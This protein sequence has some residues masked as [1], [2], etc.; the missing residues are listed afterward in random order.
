LIQSL[1]EDL[2]AI[3]LC[4]GFGIVRDFFKVGLYMLK[5]YLHILGIRI[6]I[7]VS[8]LYRI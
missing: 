1:G 8:Q 4:E 5:A 3:N 6:S 7:Q 2:K